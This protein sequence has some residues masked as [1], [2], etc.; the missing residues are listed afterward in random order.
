MRVHYLQHVPY[1]GLGYIETWL[2]ENNHSIS[3]TRFY[4]PGYALP[5][6]SD[7][8][9]LV[10]MGGPMSVYDDYKYPWLR[11]EKIFI[12]DSINAGKKVL[13]IC[14]GAQLVALCLGA[15]IHTAQ[16]QEIGWFRVQPTEQ[17]KSISWLHQ[18]FKDE[19]TVFHWHGDQFEIPFDD[20]FSFFRGKQ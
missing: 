5:S 11:E 17:I 14:L 10:I 20:S 19:P 12:E 3:G 18:L 15:N 6:I 13:G 8:D 4:E 7:I 16:H 9:A 2:K 1:E